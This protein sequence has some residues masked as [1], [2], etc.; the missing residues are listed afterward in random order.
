MIKRYKTLTLKRYTHQI[1]QNHGPLEGWG[2]AACQSNSA[3]G[4]GPRFGVIIPWSGPQKCLG[5]SPMVTPAPSLLPIQPS[6]CTYEMME[7]GQ[8]R[9]DQEIEEVAIQA[10]WSILHD[11]AHSSWADRFNTNL[12]EGTV[13]LNL[14]FQRTAKLS[15][16]MKVQQASTSTPTT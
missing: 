12:N 5:V 10:L 1:H 16:C 13:L 8:C 7:A 14:Y 2:G 3:G 4:P 9:F 11:W 6:S 15:L